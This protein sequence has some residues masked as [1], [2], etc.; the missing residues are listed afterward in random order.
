MNELKTNLL[1]KVLNDYENG[2]V[3]RLEILNTLLLV[4]GFEN[5]NIGNKVKSIFRDCSKK[6][7]SV[8][9]PRKV[10]IEEIL[11]RKIGGDTYQQIVDDLGI[12]MS[13]VYRTFKNNKELEKKLREE[14]FNN[15]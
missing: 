15:N 14:I 7:R 1:E 2:E 10:P 6:K 9:Q 8:G 11:I 5:C 12:S 4:V 3:D 13:T